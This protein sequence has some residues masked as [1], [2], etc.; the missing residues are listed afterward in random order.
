MRYWFV[1]TR[2]PAD[3]TS[4]VGAPAELVRTPIK[5]GLLRRTRLLSYYDSS[6][7]QPYNT[8]RPHARRST[9]C[10]GFGMH[11]VH[12]QITAHARSYAMGAGNCEFPFR[13]SCADSQSIP[14]FICLLLSDDSCRIVS[15]RFVQWHSYVTYRS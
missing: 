15:F 13:R 3:T 6:G 1:Q 10:H 12:S 8:G 4:Y 11:P 2:P 7:S 5:H 14:Y 9:A